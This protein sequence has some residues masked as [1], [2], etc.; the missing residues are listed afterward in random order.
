MFLVTMSQPD[1]NT[2]ATLTNHT[3]TRRARDAQLLRNPGVVLEQ[4]CRQ[5]VLTSHGA[6]LGS[7]LSINLCH[8]HLQ[9]HQ[10]WVGDYFTEDLVIV[11]SLE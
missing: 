5:A 3:A 4:G 10:G 9:Q 7:S 11:L 1:H 6:L 8:R 2:V